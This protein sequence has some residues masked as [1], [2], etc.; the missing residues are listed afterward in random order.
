MLIFGDVVATLAIIMGTAVAM[1]GAMILSALLFPHKSAVS[2]RR[3]ESEPW[4]MGFAGLV[5]SFI[6]AVPI[7]ILL[8]LPNPAAKTLGFIAL[9]FVLGISIIGSGGLAKLVSER[10]RES[11]GADRPYQ[12]LARGGMLVVASCFFPVFGWFFL[13]P[14]AFLVTLGAG[15]MS[16]VGRSTVRIPAA[17][18]Q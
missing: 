10:V 12:G 6:L 3:I 13:A 4:K 8:N 2:A 9:C 7:L 16:I 14:L 17:E 5:A 15:V 18:A 1:W 11:G